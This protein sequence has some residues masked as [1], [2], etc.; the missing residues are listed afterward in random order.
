MKEARSLPMPIGFVL[1]HPRVIALPNTAYHAVVALSALY[2]VSGCQ[3]LPAAPASMQTLARIDLR[4]WTQHKD[5]IH[6]ALAVILPALEN[7]H[8]HESPRSL[9][10]V[11]YQIP[12]LD[13]SHSLSRTQT[14]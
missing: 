5:A 8:K 4:A 9:G 3:P 10:G 14:E 1:S 12:N 6:F 13:L 2:W 7:R 11:W